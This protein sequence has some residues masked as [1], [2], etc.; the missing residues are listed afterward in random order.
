MRV[1]TGFIALALTVPAWAQPVVD[2]TRDAAYG[3]PLAVQTVETQFGDANPLGG[4]ELD[5]AYAV[6]AGGRL[7]LML[8]GNQE[9]NFNTLEIFIDA[10]PGG[11]NVL[12][13]TP[14]YDYVDGVVW[15]STVLGG[16][17]F[18]AAFAADYHLFT[19]WGGNGTPYT[20]E[21]VNRQGGGSASNPGSKGATPNAAGLVASGAILAGNVGPNASGTALSQNLEIAINDNNAAGVTGGTAAANQAAAA[22]VTTGMEF[23]VAL[24]DLGYPAPGSTIKILAAI[25][26]GDH[27]FVS[28]QL[29]AGVPAPQGNLGG[30]GSGGFTG[31]LSG[32]DFNDFGGAQYFTLQVPEEEAIPTLTFWGAAVLAL[33]L[34]GAAWLALR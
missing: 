13:V 20:A 24:A 15:R 22:A 11:E 25:N 21:F 1:T 7:Y 19:R 30:D 23:S 32:I 3:V 16:L 8:T 28:N 10:K 14:Q 12:S 2:G 27:N 26:N 9:T 18:D 31:S 6:I 4:S 29:L 17:T 5:A 34:A 33:L